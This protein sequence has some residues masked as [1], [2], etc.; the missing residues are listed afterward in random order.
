M[1]SRFTLLCLALIS[2]LI[3]FFTKDP[4]LLHVLILIAVFSIISLSVRLVF[5]TGQW[6]FGQSALA[7][8]GMYTSVLLV[9]HLGMSFWVALFL[10]GLSAA[11]VA[12]L[13]GYPSLRLKGA[14]FGMVT[15]SLILLVQ[16]TI[17]VMDSVT[18]GIR[19]FDHPI[20]PP[21][22]I[23]IFGL[24]VEFS[25]VSKV[26]FYYLI[27]LLSVLTVL[28]MYRLDNCRLGLI[29]RAIR[30]NTDL[31]E[32]VGINSLGYRVQVFVIGAFFTGLAGSFLAH[33]LQLAH[34]NNFSLWTSIYVVAYAILGGMGSVVGPIVGT[35]LMVGTFE[36]LRAVPGYQSVGYAIVMLLVI[37]FLPH[38]LISLVP[39]SVAGVPQSRK[40][41]ALISEHGLTR[42]AD[43]VNAPGLAPRS[44]TSVPRSNDG[45]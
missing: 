41:K 22:P 29:Y 13:F 32:S 30:Q 9:V 43:A 21:D 11:I 38:G 8:L 34:P 17:V 40:V 10:S 27:W 35:A 20:P 14:Y 37:R 15:M 5:I 45:R 24:L 23:R 4:Y 12:L 33:Y 31:A 44:G 2:G 1:G 18:G 28:V 42:S 6:N 36:L 16:Q 3:P 25:P 19:G 26:P 7:L 39:P